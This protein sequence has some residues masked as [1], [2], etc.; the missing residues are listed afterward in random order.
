MNRKIIIEL[1]HG[2]VEVVSELDNVDIEL[3]DYDTGVIEKHNP[4][5]KYGH[6]TLGDYEITIL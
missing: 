2:F 5:R 6:D 4:D 1:R 3:H